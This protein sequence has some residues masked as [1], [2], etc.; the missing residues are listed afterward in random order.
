MRGA[1]PPLP[2]YVLMAWCVKHRDNLE[3]SMRNPKIKRENLETRQEEAPFW[4]RKKHSKE[5]CHFL[6]QLTLYF[7]ARGI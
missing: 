3:D 6:G 1:I 5:Q 2:Q 7:V 4:N